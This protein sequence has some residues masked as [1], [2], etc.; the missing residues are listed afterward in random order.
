M[1]TTIVFDLKTDESSDAY[2]QNAP[3]WGEKTSV[4]AI[5]LR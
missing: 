4:V 2:V 5:R 1:K 3:V